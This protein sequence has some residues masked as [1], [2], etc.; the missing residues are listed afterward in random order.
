MRVIM[1]MYWH[2]FRKEDVIWRVRATI[3]I[4]LYVAKNSFRTSQNIYDEMA[5]YLIGR[6][7]T[8]GEHENILASLKL[9][10]IIR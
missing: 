3:P 6:R 9:F 2:R 4:T 5:F 7:D 10:K 8:R 1:Y